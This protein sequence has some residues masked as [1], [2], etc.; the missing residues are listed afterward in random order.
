MDSLFDGP[1]RDG[2]ADADPHT[3]EPVAL[4]AYC[5]TPPPDIELTSFGVDLELYGAAAAIERLQS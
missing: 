3:L 4:D 5:M 2:D 1:R